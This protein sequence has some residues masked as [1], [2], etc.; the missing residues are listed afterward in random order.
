MRRIW[1]WRRHSCLLSQRAFFGVSFFLCALLSVR[2][3]GIQ[4]GVERL[5]FP[6]QLPSGIEATEVGHRCERIA[7]DRSGINASQLTQ[8]PRP[9][10]NNSR[11]CPLLHRSDNL[12][13]RQKTCPSVGETQRALGRNVN[14][15]RPSPQPT[16]SMD[17]HGQ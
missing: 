1:Q 2:K 9:P 13:N 8:M 4:A 5:R 12:A 6:S 14:H 16:P 10:A 11:L 7:D 3:R 15:A 17:L